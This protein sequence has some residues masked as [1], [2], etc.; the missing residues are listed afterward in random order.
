MGARWPLVSEAK[1]ENIEKTGIAE[2]ISD[3]VG[4]AFSVLMLGFD[5][6]KS[7]SILVKR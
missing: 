4:L 3:S 2:N 5:T 7:S 6:E 1:F